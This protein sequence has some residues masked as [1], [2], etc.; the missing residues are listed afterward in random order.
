LS[1]IFHEVEE[2]VRRER[3]EKLWKKY[4]DYVIAAAALVIIAIAGY[5]LWQRYEMNQRMKASETFFAAQQLADSGNI[6][7]ATPAF[8][9][10][11]KDAPGG[12][13]K[14][15]RLSQAGALASAGQRV[16]AVAIY[17]SIAADDSGPIGSV[18]LVR[19]GWALAD[20][21]P[22]ADLEKLL[23]PLTG[24]G[25]PWRHS[26]AEILA[27]ADFHA[28][29][30]KKAQSDFQAIADDKDATDSMRRR[31]AAMAAF[32]KGGAGDF[33]TVPPPP[34]TP[35]TPPGPGPANGAPPQ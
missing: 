3:V 15:A 32:L 34:V 5:E 18:A 4:G 24:P 7:K 29:E 2:E 25:N 33:G 27:Y 11:A 31:A 16:E 19:A 10:L 13:A 9:V 14:M 12:Y 30:L 35:P 23:A 21:A 1:D 28:G 17:K 8:A 6:S 22:R 20:S 26:A